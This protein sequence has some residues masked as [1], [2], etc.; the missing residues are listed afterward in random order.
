MIIIIII[1]IDDEQWEIEA[2]SPLEVL[3]ALSLLPDS[4]LIL[5]DNVPIPIDEPLNNGDIIR[6]IKVASGG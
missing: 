2:S 6:A 1:K 5:R 3:Q 4:Y